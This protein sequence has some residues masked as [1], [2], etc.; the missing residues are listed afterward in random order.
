MQDPK[1]VLTISY[2]QS[3]Q[4]DRILRS[5]CDPMKSA[6]IDVTYAT[7]QPKQPYP[8]PWP[9][10][11]FFNIFPETVYEDG[12]EITLHAPQHADLDDLDFDLVILGYQVW[13]LAPSLPVSSFLATQE[14]KKL[15]S[16]R[17]VITVIGCRNMWLMA[18]ERMKTHLR[19]IGA[20]LIDN[21][22][23]T[24]RGHSA[25]TFLSTPIW[26]LTG[27][28]GPWLNGIVPRAGVP[29]A[30]IADAQR[31]GRAIS[32]ALAERDADDCTPMLAGLGAVRI[33]D[34]LIQSEKA[35]KRSFA[36]W[37]KFLRWLGPPS[38]RFRQ[39]GLCFFVLFLILLIL[40]VVPIVAVLKIVLKPFFRKQI[41][42]ERHYYAQPSGEF[43]DQK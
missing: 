6:G 28:R 1:R 31:F 11:R 20:V 37:G 42:A 18:Q 16:G 43:R 7:I 41:E 32:E 13:F 38:S 3:G 26:V 5:I 15:L 21:I 12:P 27:H 34:K 2:S 24:D 9:V 22:A 19:R 10:T 17:R 25:M 23:L 29:D 30:D 8:F 35:G 33:N 14:A 39:F 36:V 40:T 4:I